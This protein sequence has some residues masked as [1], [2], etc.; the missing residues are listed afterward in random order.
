MNEQ[1]WY[2]Y[3]FGQQ[4][5]PF[6]GQQVK[7]MLIGKMIAQDAY[8]FKVGWKDWRPVEDTYGELGVQT[9]QPEQK[10]TQG[11]RASAPRATI[12][13][14]VIVHNDG[15]LVI[16]SGVNISATG[17]FVETRDKIF[18]VGE[19]IKLSVKAE[20]FPRAFNA[21]AQVVR[22]NDDPNYPIGYGLK[23]ENLEESI[24]GDIQAAVDAQNKDHEQ[25]AESGE[26]GQAVR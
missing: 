24:A 2:I 3:Q 16:G 17:I 25:Q 10:S 1:I 8:L 21:V 19:Q 20:G 26:G 13:G 14:R 15:E 22:F 7:Q 4:M 23:F 9:E 11:R 6:A 12:K 5:G 18:T